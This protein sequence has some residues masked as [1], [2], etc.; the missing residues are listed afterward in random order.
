MHGKATI[1]GSILDS[2]SGQI[3]IMSPQ[4]SSLLFIENTHDAVT[5]IHVKSLENGFEKL[6]N[7][8]H[9]VFLIKNDDIF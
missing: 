4:T 6:L 8:L 5:E 9:N 2:K 7:N 1:L 3:S